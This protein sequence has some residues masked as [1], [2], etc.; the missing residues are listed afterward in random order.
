MARII[1]LS[2]PVETGMPLY[3]A[4]CSTYVGTY[5]G[6]A[7]TLRPGGISATHGIIVMSDHAGTHI[8][9]PIHFNPKGITMDRVALDI[10]YGPAV[11][12]DF[13]YKPAGDTVTREEVAKQFV[14]LKL[15]PERVKIILFRTGADSLYGKENYF[16]HYLDIKPETVI[17]LLEQGIKLFGVDASTIDGEAKATHMLLREREFYHM[18]NLTNLDKLGNCIFTFAGF[19]LKLT[20]ASGSPIRAVAILS[21]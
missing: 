17:W 12:F 4:L 18:E 10:T 19:P 1:D 6:H 16:R 2:R 20:G 11:A 8:D 21:E 9:A 14:S 3:P 15:D 7:D 5:R 13:S